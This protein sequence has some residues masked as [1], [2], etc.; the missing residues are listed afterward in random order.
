MPQKFPIYY[1]QIM[2]VTLIALRDSDG[3]IDNQKIGD[4]CGFSGDSA[5]LCETVIKAYGITRFQP[6][7]EKASCFRI[8]SR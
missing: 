1:Q 5:S 4:R 7:E 2:E 6:K 8:N 3:A